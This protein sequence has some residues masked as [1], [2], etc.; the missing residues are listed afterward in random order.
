MPGNVKDTSSL[1]TFTLEQ[2]S[3]YFTATSTLNFVGPQGTTI[4]IVLWDTLGAPIFPALGNYGAV[5][6]VLICPVTECGNEYSGSSFFPGNNG[7]GL[8]ISAVTP[9]PPVYCVAIGRCGLLWGGVFELV[10]RFVG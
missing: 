5:N 9:E 10:R 2:L 7:A 8:V 1:G 6:T 4:Q 3:Q